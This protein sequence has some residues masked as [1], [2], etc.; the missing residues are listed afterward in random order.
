[1]VHLDIATDDDCLNIVTVHF[2][3]VQATYK[4]W[5]S[6]IILLVF[7]KNIIENGK[8][9]LTDGKDDAIMVRVDAALGS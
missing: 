9:I 6:R 4:S 3:Y 2:T 5:E 1:M 7:L 8:T